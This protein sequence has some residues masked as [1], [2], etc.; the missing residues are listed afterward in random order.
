MRRS[1][2]ILL[3]ASLILGLPR[4]EAAIPVVEVGA[5]LAN[6]ANT[7][8]QSTIT[9]V[10]TVAMVL[11]QILE[12]SGLDSFVLEGEWREDVVLIEQLVAEGQ[13]LSW[14]LVSLDAQLRSLFAL[15]SAPT[16]AVGFS[17]RMGEIRVIIVESY[18]Y[19]MRTQ[20]LIQTALRTVKHLLALVDRVR[21]FK[22]FKAAYPVK[23]WVDQFIG[24]T[25]PFYLVDVGLGLFAY[26]LTVFSFV[27]IALHVLMTLIEFK[28]ALATSAVLLP[29]A[30]FSHTAFVGELAI[31]WLVAGLVRI[32]VTGIITG[33]ATTLFSI[34]TV[35]VPTVTGPD[36]TV[37]QGLSLAAGAFVFAVLAWVVPSRAA[38]IGG[39]GMA[40]ALTGEHL[41]SG[42]LVGLSGA[43]YLQQIGGGAI[44]GVSRLAA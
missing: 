34:L 6:T 30:V 3:L 23:V 44:H 21:E 8:I 18:S 27:C 39:R 37:F 25:L 32:L 19:A 28:L 41:V 33:I 11:N 42:G 24:P 9:A 7:S 38:A 20:V 5:Q 13:Q 17:Q 4:S 40:L 22:G 36:P 16:T 2:L 43:R 12:L 1:L 15:E 10:Q 31:S 35:P 29:W 14:D 26:T